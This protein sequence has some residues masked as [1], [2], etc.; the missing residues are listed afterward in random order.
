[1]NSEITLLQAPFLIFSTVILLIIIFF[2]YKTYRASLSVEAKLS[3]FSSLSQ[4]EFGRK[5]RLIE[6]NA[7]EHK[8]N[9]SM[10]GPLARIIDEFCVVTTDPDGVIT[11]A[12]DQFLSLSGFDYK[13]V[14]GR[15]ESINHPEHAREHQ[16]LFMDCDR[17]R[18]GGWSGDICN[19]AKNG[20]LY[21]VSMFV[22]P[23]SFIT[24]EDEGYIY[25]GSDITRI[26]SKN[27]E[28]MQAVR[29]KDE[30]IN[31][32]ESML[33]HSEKMA[34]LGT[35][36][37]GIAHEINTPIAFLSSN[38]RRSESYLDTM[39]SVIRCLRERLNPDAF[40]RVIDHDAGVD[41]RKLDAILDDY[42][43]LIDETNQGV[44]RIRAI[45]NDL[46]NFSHKG[47]ELVDSVDLENCI[48]T[49]L[50]LARNT[51][52]NRVRI[53]S[54]IDS[55]LPEI[56]GCENQLSQVLVNLLVNAAQ[57]MEDGHG[58]VAIR[59]EQHGDGCRLR[60]EDNGPGMD[61]EQ[62]SQIFEPFYTT[63]P[64]GEGTGLG[65]SI[66][67]DIVRRHG[68][69]LEVSSTPG[70][71]SCFEILLPVAEASKSHAA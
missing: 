61:D 8:L 71:G 2:L 33:L 23:L 11:F 12:N 5:M 57:A 17:A 3:E 44:Q 38:L 65:L 53:E 31:E 22:L 41:A 34:S 51:L 6:V 26:K 56:K 63:K 47:A 30:K 27:H 45:I 29:D 68:G 21:W 60:V 24:D 7:D 35:I 43:P 15:H 19:R 16:E 54:S 64:V 46:K 49:S 4:S 18:N 20:E 37:A 69:R 59:A 9:K 28:L 10:L 39:A 50:N 42:Q 14:I 62:L 67:Q 40:N 1:M 70:E 48:N 13:D 66:S 55:A 25:F 52:K 32:V 58:R 36:S